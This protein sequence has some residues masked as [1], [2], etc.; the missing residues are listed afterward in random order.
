VSGRR[1]QRARVKGSGKSFR[2]EDVGIALSRISW[3]S[4]VVHSVFCHRFAL[5]LKRIDFTFHGGYGAEN[6]CR[7]FHG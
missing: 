1:V 2:D 5:D 7:V 3:D 4:G 6:L